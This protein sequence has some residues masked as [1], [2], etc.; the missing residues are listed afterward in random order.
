MTRFVLPC[1]MVVAMLA[2]CARAPSPQGAKDVPSRQ[3]TGLHRT[4]AKQPFVAFLLD[5]T[6]FA[7]AYWQQSLDAIGRILTR[8]IRPHAVI[9]VLLID[10]RSYEQSNVLYGPHTLPTGALR[11]TEE[12]RKVKHDIAALAPPPTP[13]PGT[14]IE[15]A[16]H[17][18][19]DYTSKGDYWLNLFIFSDLVE[20][21]EPVGEIG[22]APQFPIDSRAV[23]LF[24]GRLEKEG[25]WK[26]K[27]RLSTWKGL[28]REYGI[29]DQNV[30]FLDPN[31][32]R[33]ENLSD[34]FLRSLREVPSPVPQAGA[35]PPPEPAGEGAPLA[36]PG[37]EEPLPVPA[38]SGQPPGMP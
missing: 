30:V 13:K 9:C 3:R 37:E 15:G 35:I 17:L 20:E 24:V 38:G 32:S 34:S 7:Q 11:A 31:E 10:D 12:L 22:S 21:Y 8:S 5:G 6:G 36:V 4:S 19:A 26:Y 25:E 29:A 1:I 14:D 2:G 28:F 23:C 18:L 27:Q 33:A 16:L